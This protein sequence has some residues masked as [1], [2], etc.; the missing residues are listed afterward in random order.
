MKR[1]TTRAI[2]TKASKHDAHGS[3]RFPVYDS[4]AFEFETAEELEHAFQGRKPAHTYSRI[5]NP[6]VEFFEKCVREVSGASSVI[7]F[8]SG[9]AAIA[10]LTISLSAQGKNIVAGNHL[11]GNTLSFFRK[12]MANFGVT[13][14]S[15]D[16]SNPSTLAQNLESAIDENTAFFYAESITNPQ[17]EVPD[18]SA[19]SAILK[20]HN[21]LFVADTTLSP[22]CM[23]DASQHGIN[24]EILSSTKFIS[25]GAGAVGGL[26]LDHGTYPWKHHTL[27]HKE[28]GA[29]GP[30]TFM[31]RLRKEVARNLGS[32]LSPHAAFLHT[33]GMETLCL[34]AERACKNALAIAL[35]LKEKNITVHYPGLV[36]DPYHTVAKKQFLNMFGSVLTF[37]LSSKEECYRFM[38]RLKIIRRATNVQDNKTLIIHPASTIFSDFTKEEREDFGVGEH[39]IRLSAGIEDCE[40]LISDIEEAFRNLI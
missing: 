11:F 9:M 8:S 7:A 21:I 13:L 23:L 16:L 40:D 25:G 35:F 28:A 14:R 1:F 30:F 4:A 17:M 36:S 2:H 5:T 32:C 34:R 3:L 26:L 37:S 10:A 15:I 33:L 24:I 39:L 22:F 6:T 27:L 20:K 38:D 31:H 12:T 29:F 18:L 19:I